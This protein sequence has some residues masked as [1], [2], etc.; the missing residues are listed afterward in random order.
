MIDTQ[1]KIVEDE[2]DLSNILRVLWKRKFLMIFIIFI[3]SLCGLIYIYFQDNI[4]M[5][6]AVLRPVQNGTSQQNSSMMSNLGSLASLAGLSIGGGGGITPYN[7]MNAIMQDTD[8]IYDFVKKNNFEQ[9]VVENYES[10]K[11]KKKYKENPKYYIYESVKN[12]LVFKENAKTGLIT[13]AYNNKDREFAK[14]FIDKILFTVSNEYKTLDM[15]N[16]D[17]RIDNYKK[18]I[19]QTDDITLKNKL[20][21]IVTGLIQNKVVSNAQEFYGFEIVTPSFIPDDIDYVKPNK[22]ILFGVF[23]VFGSIIAILSA[24]LLE[25]I[26]QKKV[27]I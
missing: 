1:N 6:K 5:S 15:L 3:I 27:S 11:D 25:K 19:S 8:F 21:E 20:A 2:I 22:P 18:E 13:I 23:F 26:K 10:K 16:M 24:L 14:Q 17:I 4:Y 9:K 7:T 12:D